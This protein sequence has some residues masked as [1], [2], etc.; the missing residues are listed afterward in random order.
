MEAG[1]SIGIL[2]ACAAVPG[3]TSVGVARSGAD[4]GSDYTDCTFFSYLF[5]GQSV[6]LENAC[7]D[8]ALAVEPNPDV[9]EAPW[10]AMLPVAGLGVLVTCYRRRRHSSS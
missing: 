5:Q 3:H 4:Q 8:A 9:P 6:G 10:A 2:P 1:R 7:S